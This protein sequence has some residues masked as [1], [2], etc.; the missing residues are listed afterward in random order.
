MENKHALIAGGTGLVGK[1]LCNLLAANTQYES[2]FSLVRK[3]T[4]HSKERLTEVIVNFEDLE[5]TK[6]P[7]AVHEAYC[8]L[9]TTMKKAGSKEAFYKVDFK[10][11]ITFAEYALKNGASKFLLIT[12]M[13]SD[14]NSVFYYNQ[15][16][17]K[18]EQ[19]ISK[20]AFESIHIFR[21]SMLLGERQESRIGE[22]IGK[23]VMNIFNPIIP[24]N[25]KGIQGEQVAKG[26]IVQ[27]KKDTIGVH[28]HESGAIR[29]MA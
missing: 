1:S 15:V 2:V 10:Y 28:I 14:P 24:A 29:E 26:M 20:M 19:E 13:G 22:S 9:G 16:K 12:S 8:C 18:I 21:P 11:V 17:G 23:T 3:Q 5:K 27:A 6:L 25:Y 7:S 4:N